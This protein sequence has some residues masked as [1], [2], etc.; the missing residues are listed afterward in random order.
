MVRLTAS[1][2]VRSRVL[3]LP[4]LLLLLGEEPHLGWFALHAPALLNGPQV[5]IDL[6]LV[7][8]VL[9]VFAVLPLESGRVP[10]LTSSSGNRVFFAAQTSKGYASLD[11]KL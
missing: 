6:H 10:M 7:Q 2:F 1:I 11:L 3:P 9:L 5:L 8:G 4:F